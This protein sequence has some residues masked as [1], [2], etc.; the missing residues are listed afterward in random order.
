LKPICYITGPAFTDLSILDPGPVLSKYP[1]LPGVS[2][3]YEHIGDPLSG[4]AWHKEDANLRSCNITRAGY[5]IWLLIPPSDTKKFEAFVMR[6]WKITKPCDQFVRHLNLFLGPREIEKEG[7]TVDTICAG[8][9]DLISTQPQQYH[10]VLNATFCV[11]SSINYLLPDETF[12]YENTVHCEE[13]G[14]SPLVAKS[15]T[16]A[17]KL[18]KRKKPENNRET[19]R[20]KDNSGIN[21]TLKD[22]ARIDKH[23][24]IPVFSNVNCT[25]KALLLACG[26][27]S[28]LAIERFTLIVSGRGD[29]SLDLS[30]GRGWSSIISWWQRISQGENTKLFEQCLGRI[31]ESE[32]SKAVE[33]ERK[34]RVRLDSPEI[35]TAF[36][37]NGRSRSTFYRH[38]SNGDQ[39]KRLC[40]SKP[41]LLCFLHSS[42]GTDDEYRNMNSDDIQHFHELLSD[43]YGRTINNAGIAFMESLLANTK[44]IKL[45]WGSETANISKITESE[46]LEGLLQGS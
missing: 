39:W 23:C 40:G 9:G 38:L 28:R 35:R 33:K 46:L 6:K 20:R 31:L 4:T 2:T 10:A 14:L 7:I 26:L 13:C 32:I 42:F 1:N 17:S 36:M 30:R 21:S 12:N 34:G 11:A 25:P 8:P 27:R 18:P 15:T 19:K 41:G 3:V 5:K 16:L 45:A 24:S 43:E 22:I 37:K 29:Q 44:G